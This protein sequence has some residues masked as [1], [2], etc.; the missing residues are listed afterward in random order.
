[1][2]HAEERHAAGAARRGRGGQ[3]TGSGGEV[4]AGDGGSDDG[5]R[6]DGGRGTK[7]RLPEGG[8]GGV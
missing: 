5:E 1:M 8:D 6:R 4:A 7:R 3:L 2:A